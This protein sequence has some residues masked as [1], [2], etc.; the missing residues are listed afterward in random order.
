MTEVLK[1]RGHCI[2]RK[3]VQRLMHEMGLE[4]IYPKKNLSKPGVYL[5][6]K[7]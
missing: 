7:K 5:A 2:N 4:A 6:I 3:K 1:S